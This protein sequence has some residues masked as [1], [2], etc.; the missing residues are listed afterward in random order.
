[1]ASSF[2]T[3]AG[4]LANQ[5][6]KAGGGLYKPNNTQGYG[7]ISIAPKPATPAPSQPQKGLLDTHTPSTP[8][9]SITD[10]QG[11]KVDFHAPTTDTQKPTTPQVGT[12]Q[13]NAQNVLDTSNLTNNPE[14]QQGTQNALLV[15]A[16]QQNAQ[17]APFAGVQNNL[18]PQATGLLGTP[19]SNIFRPQTTAN[20]QGEMGLLNPLLSQAG[21]FATGEQDAALKAGQLGT[22]GATSVLQSGLPGQISPGVSA[23]NPLTGQNIPG[24]G[25]NPFG[26]GYVQGQVEAGKTSAGLHTAYGAAQSVGNNL[27]TLIKSANIN[28]TDPQFL[29][30]INQFLQTGISSN[31]QYQQFYGTIN[32]YVASLAPILGVGGNQT[33]QKTSMAAQMVSQLASGKSIIDTIKY[34]DALAA[35]KINAFDKSASG[36]LAPVGNNSSA[37]TFGWN[38]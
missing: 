37:P 3:Q 2:N 15:N 4:I 25:A 20:L 30:S 6:A 27:T 21:S 24:I 16:A 1:M 35:D 34:F 36:N 8:V 5:V 31:P 28:P 23:Y 38:G 11:N 14:Y 19:Y 18:N 17:L 29:N 22:Q 12:P 26:G 9:K 13:Q 10:N 33:D 7:G 32:D